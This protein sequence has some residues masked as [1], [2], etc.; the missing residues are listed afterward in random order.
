MLK[1]NSIALLRAE[2]DPSLEV[3]EKQLRKVNLPL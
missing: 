1:C 2:L 3:R